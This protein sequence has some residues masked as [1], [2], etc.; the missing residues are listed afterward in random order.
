MKE[1]IYADTLF[2][3]NFSMDFLALYL[4]GRML[5]A[6]PR[7]LRLAAGA[8]IGALY[9]LAV[10]FFPCGTPTR[11]IALAA[12][13]GLCIL[14]M[15]A[16]AFGWNRRR[17][18]HGGSVFLAASVGIG[19]CMNALYSLLGRLGGRDPASTEIPGPLFPI[20][21]IAAG[22][23]SL[24]WIRLRP[25]RPEER[26]VKAELTAF[27]STLPLRLLCDTGNR[28][29]EPIGGRPVIILSREALRPILPAEL[30]G[31]GDTDADIIR[32]WKLRLIPSASIG[33]KCLLV[34]FLP[35]RI[36]VNGQPVEAAAAIGDHI[37]GD[38]DGILP[39][40]LIQ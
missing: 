25:I 37:G 36:T 32:R 39:P 13:S 8:A 31:M 27:G 9:S 35:D 12:A 11:T 24:L 14:I 7:P 17:I 29:R 10:L 2:C 26:V 16:A 34:G 15:C 22:G 5:H 21:A 33:G 4:A 1:I 19:G 40:E 38:I 3:V 30:C 20:L 23:I 6:P 18:L 28:L